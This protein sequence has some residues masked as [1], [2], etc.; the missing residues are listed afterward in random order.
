MA[1]K[2]EFWDEAKRKCGRLR[3]KTGF[4]IC[5]KKG[6]ENRSRKRS[7]KERIN[8][9]SQHLIHWFRCYFFALFQEK[10]EEN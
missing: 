5:T 6:R 4:M 7:G 9:K 8:S 2:Q 10:G 1:Y 3:L